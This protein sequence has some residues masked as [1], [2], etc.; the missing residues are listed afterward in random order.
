MSCV[1]QI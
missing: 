1:A